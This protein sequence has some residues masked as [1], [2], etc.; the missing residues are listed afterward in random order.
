MTHN[1]IRVGDILAGTWGYSMIIPCFYRV[2]KVTPT[3]CKVIQLD[4]RMV[5]ST[6][7]G[8][9]QQG[10]EMPLRDTIQRGA[11]EKL[12]RY[13]GDCYKIGSRSTAEYIR[14]WDGKPIWADYMD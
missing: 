5:Q 6:D 13:D 8:Y 3:G 12:A 4:K 2:I 9:F 11:T 14:P 10:Y 7:G 1:E